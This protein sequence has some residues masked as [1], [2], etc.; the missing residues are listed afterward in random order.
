MKKLWLMGLDNL[1]SNALRYTPS[2]GEVTVTVQY[3][4]N[5]CQIKICDNGIGIQKEDL[6]YIFEPFYRSNDAIQWNSDGTGLGLS[7]VK[8]M[9][10]LHNGEILIKSNPRTGTYVEIMLYFKNDT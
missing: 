9:V 3:K 2:G 5:Q 4:I 7:I 6:T 1:I 10:E 8:Q